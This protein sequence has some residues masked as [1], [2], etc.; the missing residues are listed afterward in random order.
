[1]RKTVLVLGMML[2]LCRTTMA[3]AEL[4]WNEPFPE[5]PADM[6]CAYAAQANPAIADMAEHALAVLQIAPEDINRG[7][8]SFFAWIGEEDSGERTT[9]RYDV[10]SLH[11]AQ[12]TKDADQ[13]VDAQAAIEETAAFVQTLL[14]TDTYVSEDARMERYYDD[15][16][17]LL[18]W[19][20]DFVWDKRTEQGI[21]VHDLKLTATYSHGRVTALHLW[22]ASL[23]PA[24][25]TAEYR[26]PSARQALE[27]LNFAIAHIDPA[28]ACTSFDDP[29]DPLV[30][31]YPVYTQVFSA[32]GL[33]TPAWA[34]VRRDAQKNWLK[35][36]VL[37]DMITGDV[38]DFHDG[39]L[40][41]AV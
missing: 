12:D 38:W 25:A 22:D 24:Q 29:A 16:G 31:L 41:G 19:I 6:V 1:M 33:Y 17:V 20:V 37:V 4:V 39:R 9:L 10:S 36:P 32:D 34:F 8:D 27:R 3:R 18:P 21:A 28:H 30:A 2:L 26:C 11:Y 7:E 13:P 5:T 14:G 35:S 23:A 40:D 15:T